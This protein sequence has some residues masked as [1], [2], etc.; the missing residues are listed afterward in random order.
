MRGNWSCRTEQLPDGTVRSWWIY[1]VDG[2]AVGIV[3]EYGETMARWYI[4]AE[5]VAYPMHDA[6]AWDDMGTCDFNP[7]PPLDC[8]ALEFAKQLVEAGG[9]DGWT[10][11]EEMKT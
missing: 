5:A 6:E 4:G 8:T 10:R 1:K 2:K 7:Q 3:Q 11:T 9:Y